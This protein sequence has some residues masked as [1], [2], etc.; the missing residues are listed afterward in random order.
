M[1][2]PA[3]KTRCDHGSLRV[4]KTLVSTL[5]AVA[6]TGIWLH[7][8]RSC[9]MQKVL[10]D[11]PCEREILRVVGLGDVEREP[12]AVC[13]GIDVVGRVERPAT[14]VLQQEAVVARVSILSHWS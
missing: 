10:R 7:R 6:V 13:H 2:I 1:D 12:V 8:S 3:G 5:V 14:G 9:A 4:K 11:L